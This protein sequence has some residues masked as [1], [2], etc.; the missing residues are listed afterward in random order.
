MKKQVVLLIQE[1]KRSIICQR[2]ARCT[3]ANLNNIIYDKKRICAH[4]IIVSKK[5]IWYRTYQ[6]KDKKVI[7][8]LKET[9]E[10]MLS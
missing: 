2:Y 5:L 8:K 6:G 9:F 10:N 4:W 3:N 7:V 1:F